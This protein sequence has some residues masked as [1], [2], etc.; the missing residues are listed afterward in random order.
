MSQDTRRMFSAVVFASLAVLLIAVPAFPASGGRS[1]SN[2]QVLGAEDQ[3]KQIAVTFWLQQHDKTGFDEL[4]RQMYDRNSP[5]YHHWLTSK[6]YAARFAPSA[7]EMAIVRQHLAANNLKVVYTD[8][9]NLAVTARGTV[10]DVQRA[11]GVQLNRVLI[12]GET[13]RV[14]SAELAIPGVAGKLV[15]A[16]QGLTDTSFKSH[17]KL[18]KDLDTGKPYM[19]P[20]SKISPLS[21]VG[22]ALQFFDANCL[23][24]T[25]AH[26]FS[27]GLTPPI[28]TANYTGTRYGGNIT[29]GEPSLPPCGYDAPQ[30]DTAY[31]LTSLYKDGLDGTGETVV[32]VD[33]F[34]SDTITGDSN[35]FAAINGLPPLVPGTNFNIFYPGGPTNC[36]GNTCGWDVETSLDVQWSHSVAPGATI[37]LV[38][39]LT[40]NSGDLDIAVL[41]AVEYGLGP[42]ISNS[43]GIEEAYLATYDP[44]ELAVENAINE[45]GASFGISVNFSS[46]DDGD[47]SYAYPEITVS[48]PA[49]SP[50]AT[51]VGG[52]SLF[53]N[54]DK[55]IKLQTGWGNNITRIAT[56][57]PN[58]PL[59]PPLFEG[60]YAGAGG[61]TSGVWPLP[62][63]QASLGGSYRL[64]PD[65]GMVAD[66]YTGVEFIDTEGGEQFISVVG[67][68]SLACPTFS[69]IWAIATQAAGTWLGQAAPILYGLPAGAITDVIA[70]SGPDNV[71][72][73]TRVVHTPVV[74]YTAAELV[75]PLENTTDFMSTLYNGTSTRWYVLGFGLD[76]SLTTGPGWDN[77]TGLGTPN[78]AN[79]VAAV[80]AAE[81]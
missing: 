33:A 66:P 58:P 62:S 48:M 20:L 9:L 47:F 29:N 27:D 12:N 79:F 43:Y 73:Y 4:V 16:V 67:G 11:T 65:I 53:L 37:D 45:L 17:A 59:I 80:A 26:H 28:Q 55:S 75:P 13:H 54:P 71:T 56:Y 36:G 34:G 78:G 31:G 44:G 39:G 74:N 40:N 57:A 49:S 25:Q 23:R 51:G 50:Y 2:V 42:V 10:A 7:A 24:N 6:E 14:P 52:T 46:G 8:K 30:V 1:V 72:G 68:T 3:S 77:V 22:P 21:K 19:I 69:G 64:V 60:F 5:N 63:F 81:N 38:L 70:V 41:Y 76:T 32:I 61:G 18:S 15:Y 35:V